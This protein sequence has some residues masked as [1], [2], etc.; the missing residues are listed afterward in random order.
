MSIILVSL[1]FDPTIY[2]IEAIASEFFL[3]EISDGA[4][5]DAAETVWIN[6]P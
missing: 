5:L 6:S 1:S 4:S 3:L 2:Q